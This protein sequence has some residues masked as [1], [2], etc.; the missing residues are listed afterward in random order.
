MQL[1]SNENKMSS[2]FGVRIRAEE[3]GNAL[4]CQPV[5]SFK[6]IQKSIKNNFYI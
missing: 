5:S 1:K 2:V 4:N 3:F 6:D